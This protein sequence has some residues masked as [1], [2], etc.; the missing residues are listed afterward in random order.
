MG[1][2]GVVGVVAVVGAG[3]VKTAVAFTLLTSPRWSSHGAG[4][5]PERTPNQN[6]PEGGF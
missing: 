1:V 4:P 6:A 5:E 2:A 3:P